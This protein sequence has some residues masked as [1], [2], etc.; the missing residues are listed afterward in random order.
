M[1]VNKNIIFI[2]LLLIFSDLILAQ[3]N[4]IEDI[5]KN[6]TSLAT[7]ILN[8]ET[9]SLRQEA[10]YQLTNY[11]LEILN[12]KKSYLYE[13]RNIEHIYIMQ[14]KDKAFKLFTW[15][16]PYLDGTLD[17]FGIIQQCNKRGKKCKIYLL[18][19]IKKLNSESVNSLFNFDE[20]YGCIYYDV[21]PVKIG[22]EKYYTLLGWD[23]NNLK[24]NKKIIDALQIG[25][26]KSP[27]F[28]ANIFNNNKNRILIEYSSQ[29]PVLLQ[30]DEE[31]EY[32]VFDHLEPID[33]ISK[34]NFEF[35]A[36][37]LSYDILEK[38]EIGWKLK[39]NIYLNNIK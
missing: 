2:F 29:Y 28:G 39:T 14:P 9:D 16:A 24:T 8:A 38:S 34:N 35:Y 6:L 22:K 23:G 18:D 30:Y 27:V 33:G 32:I 31:L 5:N 25:K 37:N 21:I 17:Y 1:K 7:T 4:E 12:R 3:K 20:W 36:T 13:F 11:F 10:N 26:K 19:D 15:F